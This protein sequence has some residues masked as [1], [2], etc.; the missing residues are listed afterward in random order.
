ML[1]SDYTP[2]LRALMQAADIVSFRALAEQAGVSRWQ[3]QQLRQGK[4]SVMRLAV[5]ERLAARLQVPLSQLLSAFG[6]PQHESVDQA[7]QL[8]A[9]RQEYARLQQAMQQ[10]AEVVRSQLQTEA[11]QTLEAWLTQWPTA[12]HAA[13][14]NEQLPAKRLL[15]LVKPI[16]NLMEHWGV[17]AIAHVGNEVAYDPQQHQLMNGTATPGDLVR[18]RYAGYRQGDKLLQRARVSPVA[19]P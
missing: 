4:L 3:V 18:V 13:E 12:A 15:P 9:L 6:R 10:Q 14:Q 7:D 1:S 11:L 5:L 8:E 17:V 16:E 2:T 19:G